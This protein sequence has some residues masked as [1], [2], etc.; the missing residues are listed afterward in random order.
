MSDTQISQHYTGAKGEEYV[1]RRMAS[2]SQPG[3]AINY[4]YFKPWL[5]PTDVVLEFGCGNGGMLRLMQK[6][7]ARVEGLEINPMARESGAVIHGSLDELPRVAVYDAIVR[8]SVGGLR[9][10]AGLPA[11][12]L[13]AHQRRAWF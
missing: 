2:V 4:G 9:K 7:L 13:R 11:D 8:N 6:D 10:N 12:G 3:F 1:R 5:K